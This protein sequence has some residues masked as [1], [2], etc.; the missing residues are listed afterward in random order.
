MQNKINK[1][2]WTKTKLGVECKNV[3]GGFNGRVKCGNEVYDLQVI[4][5]ADCISTSVILK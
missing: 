3:F 4:G 2:E 5:D 1:K